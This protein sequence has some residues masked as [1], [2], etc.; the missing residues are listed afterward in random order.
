MAVN[1]IQSHNPK[2]LLSVLASVVNT[3]SDNF[4]DVLSNKVVIVPNQ[5]VSKWVT[6]GLS[7]ENGI[8][9]N[10]EFVNKILAFK[11]NVFKQVLSE[12]KEDV[13]RA[14][15]PKAVM[16]LRIYN[17][18]KPYILSDDL[19]LDETHPLFSLV[20]RIYGKGGY[21]QRHAMLTWLA[22][23]TA[24]LFSNYIQYR[25]QCT[26]DHQGH[27]CNCRSNW[28]ERWLHDQSIDVES[29]LSTNE[30]ETDEEI[31]LKL[32]TAQQIQHWQK[33][34]W[35][36]VIRDD[37]VQIVEIENA[38]WD[39]LENEATAKQ[40][41]SRLP[42][43]VAIFTILELPP[44]HL[45]FLRRLG[46]YID[47][48]IFH[49]NPSQ[50]YWA[51]AV[52][53]RF[54]KKK[55]LLTKQRFIDENTAK[56]IKVDDR[57]INAFFENYKIANV[58]DNRESRHPLLTRFGKQAR[59]HFSLLS[60]LSSGESGAWYDAF[61]YQPNDSLLGLF[62][63]DMLLLNDPVPNSFPLNENDESI[64]INVCHSSLRQLEVL[65][66][67][68]VLWLNQ[69]DSRKVDDILVLTPNIKDV[70]PT[71][72]NVF[73]SSAGASSIHLPVKITGVASL[74]VRNAWDSLVGR[75]TLGQGDFTH[76]DLMQWLSN[77][78]TQQFYQLSFDD[79]TAIGSM[80]ADAGFKRG[81]DEEHLMQSLGGEDQDFRFTFKY[82]IERLLL[83]LTLGVRNQFEGIV[84][85]NDVQL[86]DKGLIAK[87][88]Q[89]YLDIQ[90]RASWTATD[91][92]EKKQANEWLELI[93]AEAL[94]YS[95]AE[96]VGVD[97]I[98]RALQSNRRFLTLK[99]HYKTQDNHYNL[100]HITMPLVLFL[101]EV[102]A[103]IERNTEAAEPTGFIT[104]AELGQIRPLPYK[105][106]VLL[107]MDSGFFPHQDKPKPFDL[108]R[109]LKPELGDRSRQDDSQGAF[110]DSVV[111]AEQGLWLFY[112]GFD[113]TTGQQLPPSIVVQEFLDQLSNVV[114][115]ES[116]NDELYVNKDGV[117]IH[118]SLAPLY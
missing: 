64:R 40:A 87:L 16:K 3:N 19:S 115:D 62:Q 7:L 45:H 8:C 99:Y 26:K 32:K 55:D 6:T 110:L 90:H 88:S 34:L 46:Q 78:A 91:H 58:A 28:L 53:A 41:I 76:K 31:S 65:K 89:I 67:Q 96:V 33:W 84:A 25:G 83:G 98:N 100:Q 13:V 102:E 97:I 85:F 105:L 14:N 59:D 50:E 5:A 49:Y 72:R 56:G 57:A 23:E 113:L 36:R 15:L 51:D 52:D 22:D 71:I 11:W 117:E 61:Y 2:I 108:M 103:E 77:P 4:L 74:N 80:L 48:T 95:D 20:Q 107:N 44:Q 35:Q 106:V 66:E 9:A 114:I 104:F 73:A 63:K 109:L 30:D 60:E 82:A 79:V 29:L 111:L 70:E 69:D 118:K 10:I 112:N 21:K 81:L 24:T 92:T 27:A 94:E 42:K 101:K 47:I 12:R 1:V 86:E 93:M 43:E 54:K 17:E 37:Y 39:A 75:I 116:Q 68:L 18:V 38:F